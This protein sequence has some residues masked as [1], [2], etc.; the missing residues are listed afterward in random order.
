MTTVVAPALVLRIRSPRGYTA[1]M[2]DAASD[3]DERRAATFS[4]LV[5]GLNHDLRNPISNILGYADLVRQQA[6]SPLSEDQESFLCRI[7]ENCRSVLT[8]LERLAEDAD[9][10]RREEPRSG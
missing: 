5:E 3:R 4:G 8:L 1:D 6:R 2:G 9:R 10:L 7:E